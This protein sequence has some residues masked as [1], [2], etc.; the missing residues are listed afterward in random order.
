MSN[1]YSDMDP[2][3]KGEG[4]GFGL[5]DLDR[6]A[7]RAVD[8]LLGL[9]RRASALASGVL[10]LAVAFSVGGFFLGLAAL[11]GGIETV[12]TVLG[13][14][15]AFIAVA[16]VATAILRLRS[17][18]KGADTL[19]TEVRS[20]IGGN[21]QTQRTVIET[22]ESTDAAEGDGV[23]AVS[24]QFFSLKDAVGNRAGQFKSLGLALTAVTSFPGLVALAT[25]ITFVFAGLSV[26]F[27]IALAL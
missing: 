2:A 14:V 6:L 20:L 18:R 19:V 12:W 10:I 25:L 27:L 26:I 13:T 5:D 3:G 16:S 15:F 24:R 21:V 9:V 4:K 23:V 11:D 17:V 22:V 7:Q 1:E 8:A